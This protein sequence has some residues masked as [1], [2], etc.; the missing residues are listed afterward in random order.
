MAV[1]ARILNGTNNTHDIGIQALPSYM[2]SAG[3]QKGFANECAVTLNSVATGRVFIQVTRTSVSPNETFLVPIEITAPVTVDTTGTGYVI[4]RINISKVND[5][6]TNASDGSGIAVVEDVTVLPVSD[7]YVIL[8][9]LSSGTITDARTYSEINSRPL[10]RDMFFSGT[11]SGSANAYAATFSDLK[12]LRDGM[13]FVIEIANA[14]TGA[15]TFSPNGLGPFAIKKNYN[16]ALDANDFVQY[17]FAVL[18]YD[19]QNGV[20]Q[21]MNPVANG[22]GNDIHVKASAADATKDYLQDKLSDELGDPFELF[23][24]AGDEKVIIPLSRGGEISGYIGE[25]ANAGTLMALRKIE[26]KHLGAETENDVADGDIGSSSS[27]I[28][29]AILVKPAKNL[30]LSGKSIST[31]IRKIGAPADNVECFIQ[32]DSGGSP[33]GTTIASATPV[34]GAALSTSFLTYPFTGWGAVT[35]T[36]GTPYWIIFSRSSATGDASNYYRLGTVTDE[37]RTYPFGGPSQFASRYK[38]FNGISWSNVG[39]TYMPYFWNFDLGAVWFKANSSY[40]HGCNGPLAFLSE[41]ASEDDDAFLN[42]ISSGNL[43]SLI[44]GDTLF[45]SNVAGGVTT[46][47]LAFTTEYSAGGFR[48]RVGYALDTDK[49]KLEPG[50]TIVTQ[51]IAN[52]SATTTYRFLTGSGI[53]LAKMV[54]GFK[55]SAG[56]DSNLS[57][58]FMDG[59]VSVGNNVQWLDGNGVL[60]SVNQVTGFMTIGQD[61]ANSWVG[62]AI[63]YENGLVVTFTK[64]GSPD[65]LGGILT[66]HLA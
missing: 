60:P 54:A 1:I 63:A 53:S 51:T 24:P 14:N 47:A 34:A 8:A 23:D 35:L 37:Y 39:A 6:S 4:A 18:R 38:K 30:S 46:N 52:I 28:R 17:F 20:M 26:I 48:R 49:A 27:N 59:K 22:P 45:V 64:N 33:D 19:A 16:V 40:G 11:D 62:T 15:S 50:Q 5:G 25:A 61:G 31:R 9:T 32:G 36:K 29:I 42:P 66:I 65:P 3:V 57:Y 43:S 12:T 21:L 13:E 55:Y 44:A 58:G 2:L 56:N 10:P 7:P 41:T